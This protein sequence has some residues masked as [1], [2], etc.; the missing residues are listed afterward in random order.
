MTNQDTDEEIV[1]PQSIVVIGAGP[2]GLILALLLA[3]SGLNVTVIDAQAHLDQNPRATHYGP[4][5]V[6]GLARAGLLEDVRA[7]GFIPR[8]VAWRNIKGERLAGLKTDLSSDNLELMAVLP[9]NALIRITYDHLKRYPNVNF[10]W[11]SEVVEL[12]QDTQQAWVEVKGKN[13][14]K[15]TLKGDYIVGCDGANSK[16]RR[17]L[18]GDKNFPGITWEKQLVATNVS[19]GKEV[20]LVLTGANRSCFSRFTMIS[21]PTD[22]MMLILYFILIMATWQ[23]GLPT[24]ACGV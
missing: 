9:L 20:R 7:A 23:R 1:G 6:K 8:S 5:A 21:M 10:E 11:S 19:K 14:S 24:T 13:D 22:T 3:R 2:C 12:G 4:P 16:I 15:R 18:F 17:S